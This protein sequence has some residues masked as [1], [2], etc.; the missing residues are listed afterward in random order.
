MKIVGLLIAA[1]AALVAET[2]LVPELLPGTPFAVLLWTV[3][4]FVAI[5]LPDARGIAFAA[6]YG[7][8]IDAL[9]SGRLGVTVGVCVLATLLLQRALPATSMRSFG[10]VWLTAFATSVLVSMASFSVSTLIASRPGEPAA[11][12]AQLCWASGGG[13]LLAAVVSV[14]GRIIEQ[15]T[16]RRAATPCSPRPYGESGRG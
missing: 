7:F 14:P 10:R 16:D 13:A 1:Y 15:L 9:G 6:V 4:P 8:A 11:V 5:T 2:A 3:L 12:I